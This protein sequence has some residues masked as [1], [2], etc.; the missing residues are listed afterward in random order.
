MT[1][2]HLAY[3]PTFV[4]Q[5]GSQT[6]VLQLIFQSSFNPLRKHNKSASE[7]TPQFRVPDLITIVECDNN[8]W[9]V[10]ELAFDLLPCFNGV[11]N[12][13]GKACLMTRILT[14]CNSRLSLMWALKCS[15]NRNDLKHL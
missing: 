9:N 13:D 14:Q 1:A 6:F 12:D 3:L 5:F 8:L 7:L 4:S 15:L 11:G 10:I 2:A